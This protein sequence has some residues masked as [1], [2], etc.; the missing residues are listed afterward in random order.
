MIWL[1]ERAF[2]PLSPWEWYG[3]GAACSDGMSQFESPEQPDLTSQAS[4][5]WAGVVTGDT[6]TAEVPSDLNL[7]VIVCVHKAIWRTAYVVMGNILLSHY[8][9]RSFQERTRGWNVWMWIFQATSS[10]WVCI[11]ISAIK[12]AK[13]FQG[14]VYVTWN[15]VFGSRLWQEK[16]KG[17]LLQFILL[18]SNGGESE[19]CMQAAHL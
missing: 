6:V 15:L 1:K 19:V 14:F 12:G 5:L 9:S 7:S 8:K 16:K 18:G 11:C 17:V 2:S 3:T 13:R 4:L 10:F